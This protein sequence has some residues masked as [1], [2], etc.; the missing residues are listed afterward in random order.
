M[1]TICVQTEYKLPILVK[2]QQDHPVTI[3]KGV[4]GYAV[5]DIQGEEKVYAI[6][7]CDKFTATILNKSSE[8]D[9]CFMLN[10]IVNTTQEC[11]SRV[12]DSSIKF[13]DFQPQSIFESNM[14]IAQCISADRAMTQGFAEMVC[15]RY[16]KMRDFCSYNNSSVNEIIVYR[17]SSSGQII[18]NLITK[19]R[20]FQKPTYQSIH[21]ALDEMKHHAIANNIRCCNAKNCL[22]SRQN[23]LERSF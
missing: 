2:N 20:H 3:N 18:Y 13:I 17:D 4:L 11:T 21:Y 8:F 16:T 12:Y 1:N 9:S 14:P 22:W 10:T 23:G 15:R 7:D 6:Q 5:T 19:E